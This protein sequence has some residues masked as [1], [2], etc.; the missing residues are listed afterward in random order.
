[1]GG[2]AAKP[3]QPAA[4]TIDLHIT[5][6]LARFDE[7]MRIDPDG[8]AECVRI[9]NKNFG[10]GDTALGPE[11]RAVREGRL[12]PGEMFQLTALFVDFDS[13]SDKPYGSVPDADGIQLRYGGKTVA[14]GSEIPDSVRKIISRIDELVEHMPIASDHAG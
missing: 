3:V 1:L 7:H 11:R 4:R 10:G 9:E 8:S 6:Y 12:S 13:L 2:C 14:G 5:N